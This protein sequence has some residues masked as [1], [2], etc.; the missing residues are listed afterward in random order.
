MT[1]KHLAVVGDPI[2]HSLSP[3][4]HQAAYSFLGLDWD[5]SRFQVQEG[6][7]LDFL[8]TTGMHLSGLSVTMPLKNEAAALAT[9]SDEIVKQLGVANTLVK[10]GNTWKALN[11]DVFGIRQAL[12]SC[13]T[14]NLDSVSIIGAGATA[15]SALYAVAK[16][17]PQ[18]SITVYLRNISNGDRIFAVAQELGVKLSLAA[19][20]KYSVNQQLT[21]NTIPNQALTP[22]TAEVQS[23]WFLNVNYMNPNQEFTAKFNQELVVTGESMLI[24]QAIGQIRVFTTGDSDKALKSEQ[25]LFETMKRA[26]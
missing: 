5:Y 15:L 21:I 20:E 23:G 8:A 2:D 9:S 22:L 26:L 16:S 1:S 10:D 12:K 3:A 14:L 13:F 4:I 19:L 25:Q 6:N 7:L 18:S 24:W 11:T 17:S